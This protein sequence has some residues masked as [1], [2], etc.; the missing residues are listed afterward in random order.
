MSMSHIRAVYGVPAKRGMLVEV[1]MSN[2]RLAYR[3]RIRSASNHIHV[4]G[5]PFH[6][7]DN[8]VYFDDS[9]RVLLDTREERTK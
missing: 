9:G 3:G 8:V 6:P 1:Y 7:T 5:V 2:G 4:D